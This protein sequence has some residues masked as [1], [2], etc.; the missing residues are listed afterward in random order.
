M[1][2]D[3]T[4]DLPELEQQVLQILVHHPGFPDCLPFSYSESVLSVSDL[5]TDF[6]TR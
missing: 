6:L 2:L 4:G 5:G 1:G 3:V